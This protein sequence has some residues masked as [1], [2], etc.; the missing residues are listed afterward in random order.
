MK[1]LSIIIPIYNT[2]KY[3]ERCLNSVFSFAENGNV[4]VI[5]VEDCSTDKSAVL[6]KEL[7]KNRPYVKAIYNQKNLGLSISRNLGVDNSVG[8]YVWFIDSDDWIDADKAKKVMELVKISLPD[9]LFFDYNILFEQAE[10]N[11]YGVIGTEVEIFKGPISGKKTFDYL[12]RK[13]LY[14]A[15]VWKGI[16]S[17]KLAKKV[18]FINGI[19][20]ED[21]CFTLKVLNE[22]EKVLFSTDCV[23]NY[24]KR[25]GSIM[26]ALDY[27][28]EKRLWSLIVMIRSL[29]KCVSGE[30]ENKQYIQEKITR[31]IYLMK[32]VFQK[33]QSIDRKFIE[34]HSEME[35]LLYSV[36]ANLYQGFFPYKLSPTMFDV[37]KKTKN[38]YIYGAGKVGIGF[39]ELIQERGINNVSFID[40]YKKERFVKG[41]PVFSVQ[42]LLKL[43]NIKES[44]FFIMHMSEDERKKMKECLLENGVKE[45]FIYMYPNVRW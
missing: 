12:W 2:E 43:E 22:A 44:V 16:Y 19:Y 4:E 14:R 32:E 35:E 8:E 33:V 28:N 6:L 9:I 45:D 13:Q 3:L 40:S 25:D 41:V 17:R 10:K 26:Q 1:L 39:L 42:E 18:P 15:E 21:E 27:N 30:M 5:C 20:H 36:G 11:I 31:E 34:E 23:Y 7:I 37:I 24:C 29:Q 38:V